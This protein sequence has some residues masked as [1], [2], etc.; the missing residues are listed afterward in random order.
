METIITKNNHVY[1]LQEYSKLNT[2][3]KSIIDKL[4]KVL[5]TTKYAKMVKGERSLHATI[6]ENHS[7][8]LCFEKENGVIINRLAVKL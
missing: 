6:M 1:L 5:A 7:I 8:L 2:V 3:S 4:L